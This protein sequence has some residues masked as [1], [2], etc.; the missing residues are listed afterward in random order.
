MSVII[1]L[2]NLLKIHIDGPEG[3]VL[4]GDALVNVPASPAMVL[5]PLVPLSVS[6]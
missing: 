5:A 4:V 3:H 2:L 6:L 1:D